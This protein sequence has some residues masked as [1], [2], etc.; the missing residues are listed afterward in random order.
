MSRVDGR[1]ILVV[2]TVVVLAASVGYSIQLSS[3]VSNLQSDVA[4]LRSEI[5]NLQNQIS[6][7]S[8]LPR[9]N[10]TTLGLPS[11]AVVYAQV[12]D[13]V[14]LV[15]VVLQGSQ[16]E[17]SGFVADIEGHV[18]TNFHV[19]NQAV[20][21]E[22][23]FLDGSAFSGQQV[24]ADPFSDLAVL[25]IN[26]PSSQ[27]KPLGLAD[28]SRLKVGEPII[29]IGN[30][31]GLSGS[32]STGVVSQ[33]GRS[34]SAQGGFT[35]PDV[36]QIDAAVNPGNSGGPL[37]NYDGQVVGIT[38]AIASQTGVFSGVGFAIPSNA[39]TRELPS[40]ISKGS[41]AHP[42]L[43]V[44]GTDLTVGTASA[45]NLPST[46]GWLITAVV[47]GSPADKAGLRGGTTQSQIEG[48]TVT[49][50][51][52]VII[53]LGGTSI[54]NG[55]DIASYLEESTKPGQNVSLTVIRDGNE[56]NLSAT[57]GVRP[58]S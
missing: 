19:V 26:A 10:Q 20:S 33:L 27:L 43:G 55:D 6:Q 22:V 5:L 53:K 3:Q 8:T 44:E 57:L 38:T 41:F 29:A 24:G 16:A 14:V 12:K 32:L 47:S 54:R 50:G 28:S 46:R 49:I 1:S 9:T 11:P 4:G 37:L 34:L 52:D 15:R 30:P 58:S 13:S 39:I 45:M 51:G 31:F 7:S 25:K 35:I 18:V 42:W 48:R 17:G 56:V 21:I 23:G 36:I 40:L 2:V